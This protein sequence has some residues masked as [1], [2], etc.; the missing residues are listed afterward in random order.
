MGEKQ[1]AS[2]RQKPNPIGRAL[3]SYPSELAEPSGHRI[4]AFYQAKSARYV[5]FRA[6]D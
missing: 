4:K 6:S 3:P 5:N 2:R 1:E